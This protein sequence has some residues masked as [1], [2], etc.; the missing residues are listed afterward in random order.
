MTREGDIT[1]GWAGPIGLP[2]R[3]EI[4]GLKARFSIKRI[5]M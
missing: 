1:M 3:H 4:G 5:H 2:V